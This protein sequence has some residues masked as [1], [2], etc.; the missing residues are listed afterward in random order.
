VCALV[1]ALRGRY[2]GHPE[3]FVVRQ[4][5]PLE[6]H[7]VPYFVEDRSHGQ[8]SYADWVMALHKAVLN[9]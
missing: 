3:V 6:A 1:G 7:V 4:G 9:K 8:L 5:T 2:G